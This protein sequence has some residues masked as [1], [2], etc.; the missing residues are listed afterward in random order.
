MSHI[1][2]NCLTIQHDIQ[3]TDINSD[4][5]LLNVMMD[6][7]PLYSDI[8]HPAYAWPQRSYD[9]ERK[10]KTYTRTDHP[11]R[12]YYIDFGLSAKFSPGE[13]TI[14]PINIGGDKSLPEYENPLGMYNPF[15]AD[16]YTLGNLIRQRFMDVSEHARDGTYAWDGRCHIVSLTSSRPSFR[17][18]IASS[19]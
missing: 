13:E 15:K 12:Y 19:S 3:L 5:T 10:V 2:V 17:R 18:A 9:F 1:G 8:P 16:I 7:K 6:P 14:S 11:T 4:I